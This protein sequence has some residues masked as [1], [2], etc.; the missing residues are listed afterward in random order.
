MPIYKLIYGHAHTVSEQ[1]GQLFSSI[2]ILMHVLKIKVISIARRCPS[3][4][5]SGTSHSK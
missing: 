2:P 3:W 4:V 5:Q 1:V